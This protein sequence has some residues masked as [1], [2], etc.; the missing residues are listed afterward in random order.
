MGQPWPFEF[1]TKI[2]ITVKDIDF[3]FMLKKELKDVIES[4]PKDKGQNTVRAFLDNI[5]MLL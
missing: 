1:E 2:T 5:R 3:R 4:I